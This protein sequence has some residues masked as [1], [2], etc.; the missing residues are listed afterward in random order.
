MYK[1]NFLIGLVSILLIAFSCN[2]DDDI[3]TPNAE[4]NNR[5]Y[6]SDVEL[7]LG[8]QC[9]TYEVIYRDASEDCSTSSYKAMVG[10]VA[11]QE[12]CTIGMENAIADLLPSEILCSAECR[13]TYCG[14]RGG[15]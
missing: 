12:E 7:I 9:Y 5:M 15:W 10:V 13:P 8:P 11:T 1:V 3:L 6:I 2:S 4:S 14:P